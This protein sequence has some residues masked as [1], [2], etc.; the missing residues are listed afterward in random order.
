MSHQH[1][2]GTLSDVLD[3][4]LDAAASE[5][6]QLHLV[7]CAQ[8]RNELVQLRGIQRAARE[9]NPS[10]PGPDQWS[11]LRA[12]IATTQD[13]P[14]RRGRPLNRRAA[15][16]IVS[17]TLAAA[18]MLIVVLRTRQPAPAWPSH[19]A[20][21]VSTVAALD[22]I[23]RPLLEAIAP[24]VRQEFT[25]LLADADASLREIETL[26]SGAVDSM[27]LAE[28]YQHALDSKQRLLEGIRDYHH[29]GE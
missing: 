15:G 3:E 20:A 27:L 26:R 4:Q 7:D 5:A 10:E 14:I 19:V 6:W 18:A 16:Y 22:T 29:E 11:A 23:T 17:M 25:S 1:P 12:A 24:A 13:R 8:C 9:W 21:S 28:V 2:D